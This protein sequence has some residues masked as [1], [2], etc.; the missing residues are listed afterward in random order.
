MITK[1]IKSFFKRKEEAQPE[2]PYKVE[3]P[4]V[5]YEDV[6]PQQVVLTPVVSETA[7]KP[8]AKKAKAPKAEATAPK[9]ESKPAKKPRAPKKKAD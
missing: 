1:F 6:K 3:T 7:K 4:S 2:A 5:N 9:A 8:A